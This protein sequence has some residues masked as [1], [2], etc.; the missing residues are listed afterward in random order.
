MELW[1]NLNSTGQG[2]VLTGAVIAALGV[3]Y[4]QVVRPLVRGV[5]RLSEA[6]ERVES[7]T[8]E[9]TPNS[10]SHLYDAIKRIERKVDEH[11]SSSTPPINIQVK[12]E[13]PPKEQS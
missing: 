7:H 3:I 12:N 5:Q 11:I 2:I 9:L 6:L 1:D 8:I 10:G 13:H 4:R